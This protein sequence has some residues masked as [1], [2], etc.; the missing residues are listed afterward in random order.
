MNQHQ[1]IAKLCEILTP[2]NII[3]TTEKQQ[4]YTTDWRRRYNNPC[5][6]VV[7]PQ[8]KE[9]IQQ[10]VRA[11]YHYGIKFI[12]QGGNTSL[13]GASVPT[14]D[15]EQIIISLTKLNKIKT[16]NMQN[17]SIE[18]EAGCTLLEINHLARG[19]NLYLPIRI[20]SEGS[21]QI[22]G[23]VATNAGG[24]NVI[25]YGTTREHVLGLEVILPNGDIITQNSTLK[26]NNLNFDLKQLFIGSE[27]TLGIITTVSLK[28][29]PLP[30]NYFT[31]LI[32]VDNLNDAIMLM[33]QLIPLNLC[34]YEIISKATKELH[35]K[36]FKS[37]M[38][39]QA[40]WYILFELETD[41]L[42]KELIYIKLEEYQAM[43][44][45][46]NIAI[47]PN[48]REQLWQFREQIPLAEKTHS[49]AIKHDISLPVAQIDSFIK[50]NTAR[51]QTKYPNQI[52]IIIFG[53]L[54]DGNLHY[55]ISFKHHPKQIPTELEHQV[56]EIVYADIYAHQGSFAAEHGVGQLK[57]QWFKKYY[58]KNSYYLARQIKH[59]IDDKLIANIG[60]IFD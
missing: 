28:L 60:K 43:I 35:S 40:N 53:H 4:P 24:L 22:G 13:C 26:K 3:T 8:T 9:Q 58:D 42:D 16:L 7:T 50:Q 31:A 37:I 25:K 27:G 18:V 19:H 30:N 36:Y 2:D 23:A 34:A 32:A 17:S 54:G 11:C 44:L 56:N 47:T 6:A 12:P 10:I 55:N 45:D 15:P 51:L 48:Q 5:L 52:D 39:T 59:L 38:P 49:L 57:T 33:R 29:Q 41:Y 1:I 21:C 46:S 20:A 14:K